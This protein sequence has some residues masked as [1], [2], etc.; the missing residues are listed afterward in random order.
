MNETYTGGRTT[1]PHEESGVKIFLLGG[2]FFLL[3]VP[4]LLLGGASFVSDPGELMRGLFP[5]SFVVLAGASA[6]AGLTAVLVSGFILIVRSVPDPS[7]GSDILGSAAPQEFRRT[8]ATRGLDLRRFWLP[9]LGLVIVFTSV[10]FL[11]AAKVIA[12]EI[13]LRTAFAL[14]AAEVAAFV[15]FIFFWLAG[16]A[17]LNR[18]GSA[19]PVSAFTWPALALCAFSLPFIFL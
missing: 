8:V 13:M 12:P 9:C 19:L 16:V 15:L 11:A 4:A 6:A 17:R 14:E 3:V 2:F 10:R 7:H 18:A 1:I 5:L